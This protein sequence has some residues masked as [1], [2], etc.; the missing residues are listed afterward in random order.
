MSDN[1]KPEKVVKVPQVEIDGEKFHADARVAFGF[2]KEMVEIKTSSGTPKT[3]TAWHLKKYVILDKKVVKNEILRT[4]YGPS[5]KL[6]ILNAMESANAKEL[7][8]LTK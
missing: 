4:E 5:G 1:E 6:T 2:D 7:K 3:V 8:R